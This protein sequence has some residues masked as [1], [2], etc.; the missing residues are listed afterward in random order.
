MPDISTLQGVF[1]PQQI[2][3][4]IVLAVLLVMIMVGLRQRR[5]AQP[6]SARSVWR[7]LV[8]LDNRASTSRTMALLWTVLVAYCLLTLVLIATLAPVA[9]TPIP[10]G[11]IPVGWIDAAFQPLSS[12]IL[13]QLAIPLGSAVAARV[14]VGQKVQDG[15]QQKAVSERPA[16]ISQLVTDD[17][18]NLDLVDLQYVLFNTIA[19]LFVLLQFTAHPSRGIGIVPPVFAALT[20]LSAAVF[21][22]N[23]MLSNNAARLDPLL[24]TATSAGAQLLLTGDNLRVGGAGGTSQVPTVVL[25]PVDSDLAAPPEIAADPGSTGRVLSFTV[26]ADLPPDSEW[27]VTVVTDAGWPVTSPTTLHVLPAAFGGSAATR[28]TSVKT[29]R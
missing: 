21:V 9:G 12:S 8:G 27:R 2:G 7:S 15:S 17:S 29:V 26:P 19:A 5:D 14:V 6:A 28:R 22:G 24:T 3:A 18:G 11:R 16:S 25:N 20:G 13:V 1:K 10:H 23:K 4:G